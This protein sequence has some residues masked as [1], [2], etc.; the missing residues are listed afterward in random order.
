MEPRLLTDFS[1]I[2]TIPATTLRVP[3]RSFKLEVC[4][5][6]PALSL[7]E[8]CR[9]GSRVPTAPSSSSITSPVKSWETHKHSD[10]SP[11][12][13]SN[14]KFSFSGADLD[15]GRKMGRQGSSKML[16]KD[17]L[18]AID[19]LKLPLIAGAEERTP[20]KMRTAVN[21]RLQAKDTADSDSTSLAIAV[22]NNSLVLSNSQSNST[23]QKGAMSAFKRPT[24][25]TAAQIIREIHQASVSRPRIQTNVMKLGQ[26]RQRAVTLNSANSHLPNTIGASK[27]V[28]KL[29]QNANLGPD[30]P[31]QVLNE[32][33][34]ACWDKEADA[35]YYYNKKSGEATWIAPDVHLRSSNDLH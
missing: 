32:E 21:S 35:V 22:R 28:V 15:A 31:V 17:C 30:N 7:D 25:A 24:S 11:L 34:N 1:S 9:E 33:W 4:A 16:A 8:V 13:T 27:S 29:V 18:P 2:R 5:D 3:P 19:G 14:C 12:V 23:R 20:G 6:D 10:F 26:T